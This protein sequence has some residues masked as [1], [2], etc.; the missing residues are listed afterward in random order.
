MILSPEEN[1]NFV[2]I[3]V[4]LTTTSQN[5]RLHKRLIY[6]PTPGSRVLLEV[7]KILSEDELIP[8]LLRNTKY[9]TVRPPQK[10]LDSILSHFHP[11]NVL[12]HCSRSILILSSYATYFN[13]ILFLIY[14]YHPV[15][16]LPSDLIRLVFPTRTVYFSHLPCILHVPPTP[17]CV[18]ASDQC[19]VMKTY[20]METNVEALSR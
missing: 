19:P 18:T 13:I 15:L 5:V 16:R 9:L 2:C 4:N 17:S 11:V 6:L 20:E 1:G 8:L 7:V 10:K 14:Y 3:H 12:V